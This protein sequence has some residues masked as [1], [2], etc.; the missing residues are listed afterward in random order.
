MLKRMEN[1][2]IRRTKPETDKK[3]NTLFDRKSIMSLKDEYDLYSIQ[4]YLLQEV[5]EEEIT[6]FE[7]ECPTYQKES[8]EWKAEIMSIVIS[9]PDSK[10]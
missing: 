6:Q 8:E 9:R 1:H 7:P 2:T 3:E 4:G 10:T 5:F